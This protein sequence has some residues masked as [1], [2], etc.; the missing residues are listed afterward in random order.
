MRTRLLL[1]VYLTV[2]ANSLAWEDAVVYGPNR[3]NNFGILTLPAVAYNPA[4]GWMF[5]G[6]APAPW[7][8]FP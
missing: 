2:S 6:A 4:Y 8:M 7:L 1:S 5:G 3:T